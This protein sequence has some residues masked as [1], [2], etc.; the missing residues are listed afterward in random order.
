MHSIMKNDFETKFTGWTL[1]MAAV[2]LLAGWVLLPHHIGEYFVSTDFE[3]IGENLWYWIWMFRIH[4]FGWVIMGIAMMAFISL[5]FEKPYRII[6]M[7]GAGVVI[8]GTFTM[9]LAV[10]FYYTYGAWGVGQTMGK[11]PAEIQEFTDS[12]IVTNQYVTCLIRFGRIFSGAGFVLFG[13]GLFKWKIIDTWLGAFTMIMGM[14]A[15]CIILFIP[16]NFDIYKPLFYVKVFWLTIV[17]IT[18][19]R[20]GINLSD[21]QN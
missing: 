17:G 20:K 1:I 10:A 12:I 18:I 3:T 2:F 4:I 15:M 21:V 13:Y 9:A 16:D 7:P 11:S 5:T 14:T 19:L 6:L 8:V